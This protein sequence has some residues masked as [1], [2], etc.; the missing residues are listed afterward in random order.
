MNLYRDILSSVWMLSPESAASL[1]PVVNGFLKGHSTDFKSFTVKSEAYGYQNPTQEQRVVVIPVK[2]VIMKYDYCWDMGM[3][4]FERILNQAWQDPEVGAIVLDVDSGGGQAT[5]MDHVAGLLRQI[6]EDKP[7]LTHISGVCASAA[8]YFAAQSTKIYASSKLDYV[9][10]IGTMC[11]LW[12]PNENST[13]DYV[14]LDFYATKST[15]KN[16]DYQDA[17][18][19]KPQALIASLD[20]YNEEFHANVRAGRPNLDESCYTGICVLA[21]EAEKLGMIDG[22]KRLDDVV[23]EAFSLIKS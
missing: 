7:V 11:S 4:T 14:M 12:K 19:G 9:G 15:E 5:Y 16:K 23:A 18:D 6:R 10:S 2:G 22:I 21:D 8:Y 17:I 3:I 20:K 1:L 13:S